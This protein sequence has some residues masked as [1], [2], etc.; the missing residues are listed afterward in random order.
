MNEWAKGRRRCGT[1][2]VELHGLDGG[3]VDDLEFFS[4]GK[5]E[6]AEVLRETLDALGGLQSRGLV[7]GCEV[8]DG[9]VCGVL[10]SRK[11]RA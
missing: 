11:R 7:V 5:T 2:D 9:L 6:G 1:Y 4:F 10:E 3:Q 8:L